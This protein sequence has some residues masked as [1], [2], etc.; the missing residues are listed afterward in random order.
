MS[1][2]REASC[3]AGV[4]AGTW[5]RQRT[6]A[7]LSYAADAVVSRRSAWRRGIGPFHTAFR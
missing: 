4:A 2:F 7:R 5:M 6:S 1:L 3:R